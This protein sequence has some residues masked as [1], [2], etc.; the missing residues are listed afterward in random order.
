MTERCPYRELRTDMIGQFHGEMLPP[1]SA[2]TAAEL[3]VAE[4][5]QVAPVITDIV[6][7]AT[8]SPILAKKRRFLGSMI[9]PWD[10]LAAD[11]SDH[12]KD[13]AIHTFEKPEH[14]DVLVSARALHAKR[15]PLQSVIN[16][17]FESTL[18]NGPELAITCCLGLM[19]F[20]AQRG[21]QLVP[22]S[23]FVSTVA[24]SDQH[25]DALTRT[26]PLQTLI[27]AR[28]L[29]Q[30]EPQLPALKVN[31]TRQRFELATSLH[32]LPVTSFDQASHQ[33]Y[34]NDRRTNAVRIGDIKSDLPTPGCPIILGKTTKQL[35]R[36]VTTQAAHRGLFGD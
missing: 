9:N 22:E 27:I 21:K 34:N 28:R 20:M 36:Y 19:R 7:Q 18:Q 25:I 29:R 11:L 13:S 32:D 4:F 15:L 17:N 31:T 5:Q 16:P 30:K 14:Q 1:D 35:W 10:Y 26:D 8:E 23:A 2:Q 33:I 3:K 24:N 12:F 6:N